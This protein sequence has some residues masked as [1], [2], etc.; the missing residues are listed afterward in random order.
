MLLSP[1]VVNRFLIVIN[2]TPVENY[3]KNAKHGQTRTAIN[4]MVLALQ[5]ENCMSWMTASTLETWIKN[6]FSTLD[7]FS[8]HVAA[9]K[10]SHV[11]PDDATGDQIFAFFSSPGIS[12]DNSFDAFLLFKV[13]FKVSHS[14]LQ[15]RS[16]QCKTRVGR[17]ATRL[18]SSHRSE[19]SCCGDD[20]DS[21]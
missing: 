21:E 1:I 18:I 19:K 11:I 13:S 7:A 5:Q 4:D 9:L 14:S 12:F 2:S 3:P 6:I 17:R 20:N 10:D 15:W 16:R 8:A